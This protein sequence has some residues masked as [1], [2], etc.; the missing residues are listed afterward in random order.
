M[1]VQFTRREVN[2]ALLAGGF[3]LLSS[4]V[5]LARP[6]T[7]ATLFDF[8]I[9]GGSYHDLGKV[10]GDLAIGEHLS[11]IAEPANPYDADAVA[12]HRRRGLKLGYIP[13]AANEPIARL[14]GANAH[15]RAVVVG[16][17]CA[18]RGDRIPEDLVFTGF[19]SG[20]PQVRLIRAA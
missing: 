3:A 1:T 12:V 16:R 15:L 14:L 8:A 5:V 17:L 9:A 18:R 13:R 20:D 7:G 19:I 6:E 2:R 10:R 4:N 11:L